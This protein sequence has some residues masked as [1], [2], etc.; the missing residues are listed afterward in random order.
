MSLILSLII[1]G[2]IFYFIDMIPMAEPFAKIIKV[3]AIILAVV[4]VLQFLGVNTG[5]P[6]FNVK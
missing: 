6:S 5:L 4:M 3:V 2:V 1:L